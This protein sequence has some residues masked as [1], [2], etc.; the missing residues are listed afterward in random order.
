MPTG[1]TVSQLP[2]TKKLS[3]ACM[4]NK[5]IIA[6]KSAQNALCPGLPYAYH[7]M[8]KVL[9]QKIHEPIRYPNLY[10]FKTTLSHSPV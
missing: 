8:L 3:S 9:L 10:I 6:A 2:L 7:V 5:F 1:G 4:L